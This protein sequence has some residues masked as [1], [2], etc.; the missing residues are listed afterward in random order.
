MKVKSAMKEQGLRYFSSLT[1]LQKDRSIQVI[2]L[3]HNNLLEL[4]FGLA[5]HILKNLDFEI[6]IKHSEII[7]ECIKSQKMAFYKEL[8]CFVPLN[9]KEILNKLKD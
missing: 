2:K 3:T 4:N 8:K 9:F 6:Q 5:I 1:S 7:S